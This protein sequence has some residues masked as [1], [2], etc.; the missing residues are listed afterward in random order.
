MRTI[1]VA[2]L[3]CVSGPG[4]I[5]PRDMHHAAGDLTMPARMPRVLL[6]A[7]NI[8]VPG[9]CV[10]LFVSPLAV[11]RVVGSCL[12]IM[13]VGDASIVLDGFPVSAS[14]QLA[15]PVA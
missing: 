3:T 5:R 10:T 13:I 11:A 4:A 9:M 12:A 14:P 1:S 6:R 7:G 2:A 15:L 8:S